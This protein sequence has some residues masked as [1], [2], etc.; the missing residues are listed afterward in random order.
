MPDAGGYLDIFFLQIPGVKKLSHP[1]HQQK[2][3]DIGIV[4]QNHHHPFQMPAVG[5]D[6]GINRI[7][8][9]PPHQREEGIQLI[10]GFWGKLG[11]LQ[12]GFS[13]EVGDGNGFSSGSSGNA[14]PFT[15]HR[16]QKEQGLQGVDHLL[17]TR[18]TDGTALPDGGIPNINRDGQGTGVGGYG[19]SPVPGPSSFQDHHWFLS[20]HLPK[21]LE[22]MSAVFDPFQVHPDRFY[23]RILPKVLQEI[24]GPDYNTVAEADGFVDD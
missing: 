6:V 12:T 19:P 13:Q 5:A 1:G 11:N 22:K 14:D 10:I 21:D 8:A 17:Q 23:F 24:S 16:R 15:L 9:A 3:V 7:A 18:H 4:S 2:M 20:R